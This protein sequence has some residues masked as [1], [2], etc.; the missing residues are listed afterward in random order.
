M[1]AT[2]VLRLVFLATISCS[3]FGCSL[4]STK[5]LL[6]YGVVNGLVGDVAE[7]PYWTE[8]YQSN[9]KS[10]PK[11]YNDLKTFVTRKSSGKIALSYYDEVYFEPLEDGRLRL[12]CFGKNRK[13]VEYLL[14]PDEHRRASQVNPT[15]QP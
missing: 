5:E 3:I 12:R 8:C 15:R 9:R 2:I 1:T 4:K 13:H 14:L 6:A 10:W 7:V 11:D